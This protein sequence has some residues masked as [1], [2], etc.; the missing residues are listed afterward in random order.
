MGSGYETGAEGKVH[1]STLPDGLNLC[2][3][4]ELGRQ[5]WGQQRN[6][7]DQARRLRHRRD[8]NQSD[9]RVTFASAGATTK[10][11]TPLSS[12]G[13]AMLTPRFGFC[14]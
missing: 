6:P 3:R 7:H 2:Q 14:P 9:Q 10:F 13:G 1:M 8:H 4:D 5:E 11:D 12:A